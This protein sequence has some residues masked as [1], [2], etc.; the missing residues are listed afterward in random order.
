METY[1]ISINKGDTFSLLVTLKDGSDVPIDLTNY[2]ISG[3]ARFRYGSSGRLLDLGVRKETPF[4][5]GIISFNIPSYVTS[6]LPVSIFPYDC[7]LFNSGTLETIKILNGKISTFP[8]T[9]F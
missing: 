6:L 9:T 1:D 2:Q 7:E 8:E 5:S 3:Y 4:I